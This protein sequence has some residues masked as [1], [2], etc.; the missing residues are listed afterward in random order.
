MRHFRGGC[1][2]DVAVPLRGRR[3]ASTVLLDAELSRKERGHEVRGPAAQI[4]GSFGY[5]KEGSSSDSL[6]VTF[7]KRVLQ[8]LRAERARLDVDQIPRGRQAS[9][10]SIRGGGREPRSRAAS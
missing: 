10:W 3:T 5:R 2:F 6:R 4:S 8:E 7:V 1:G 9:T